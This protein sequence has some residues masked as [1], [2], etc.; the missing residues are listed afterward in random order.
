[1]GGFGTAQSSAT[2]PSA[3]P[4]PIDWSLYFCCTALGSFHPYD[5]V[6][7]LAVA[8]YHLGDD[9]AYH[10]YAIVVVTTTLTHL[11]HIPLFAQPM[12]FSQFG[13]PL[14]ISVG[15]TG[16]NLD[17]LDGPLSRPLAEGHP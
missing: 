14:T 16:P 1:L 15:S 7:Q 8:A 11:S 10:A 12:L 2:R 13:L 3:S 17:L 9:G 4:S 6:G 5:R